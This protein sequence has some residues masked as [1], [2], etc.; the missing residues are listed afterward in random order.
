VYIETVEPFTT[1]CAAEALWGWI[2]YVTLS[3]GTITRSTLALRS[4]L[5]AGQLKILR[6]RVIKGGGVNTEDPLVG[7]SVT[8]D[9]QEAGTHEIEF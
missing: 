9:W 5:R 8:L 1:E 3:D 7:V 4:P 2:I 6:A